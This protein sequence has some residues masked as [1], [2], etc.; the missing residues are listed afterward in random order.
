M[1]T[2]TTLGFNTRIDIPELTRES[3]VSL[4][5]QQ[6]A[7]T[8]DLYTQIKQAHWNV[9]GMDFMPLHLFFDEL[10]ENFIRY[11]DM[12]AE[13]ATALGGRAEG[14]ARMAAA[15]S[16]IDELPLELTDG[17]DFVI[18]LANRFSEYAASLRSA[19]DESA[20]WNDATSSDLFTEISREVD[21]SLWFIESHLQA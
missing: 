14:T 17:K 19:I 16:R 8:F 20:H 9:K 15:N 6:L 7:D 12:L 2:T 5:N 3:M 21:K 18:A 1:S 10:A 13:R 11:A 4:L